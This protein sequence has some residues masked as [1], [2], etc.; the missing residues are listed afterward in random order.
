MR[1][2]K[3][4]FIG[5]LVLG[6]SSPLL[7]ADVVKLG[8]FRLQ[9]IIDRSE[10]GKAGLG[11]FQDEMKKVRDKLEAQRQEVKA[12]RD[13]FQ[14]KEQVW[15][16]DVKKKK[17]QQIRVRE[18]SVRRA[19]EQANRDLSE[20][21]RTILTP[22]KDKMLEVIS[23][24]G[25]EDGYTMILDSVQSGMAYA[26]ASLDLTDQIIRELNKLAAKEAGGKP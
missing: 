10:M 3:T 25:E 4:V 20:R 15:S 5:F 14:M 9:T 2:C 23:R 7:A 17:L 22:L 16:E 11:E 12:M 24:I 8:Y 21:E 26:P 18:E 13:E 19:I 1:L 6:F